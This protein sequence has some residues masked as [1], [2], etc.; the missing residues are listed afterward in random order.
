[1]GKLR[2][3]TLQKPSSDEPLAYVDTAWGGGTIAA[4]DPHMGMI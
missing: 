2:F 4:N 1:M 3:P